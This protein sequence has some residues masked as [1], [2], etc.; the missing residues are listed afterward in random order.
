VWPVNGF[1]QNVTFLIRGLV[2]FTQLNNMEVGNFSNCGKIFTLQKKIIRI[3]V[4]AGQ[5]LR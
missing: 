3:M 4:G 2:V 1:N 5:K